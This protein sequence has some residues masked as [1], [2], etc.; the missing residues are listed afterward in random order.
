MSLVRSLT[1]A[2]LVVSQMP[3]LPAF[4]TQQLVP[5]KT[6][7]VKNPPSGARKVLWKVKDGAAAVVGDPTAD[8]AT[9]RIQLTNGG[10]QCVTMPAS[11][12]SAIG[13]IGFKYKDAALANGPVKVAQIK[14]TPSGTFILKALLKNGGP[15]S[16]T[17]APGD[18]TTSYATNFTL[19]TGDEYCGG[20]ATATPNPNNATTF[21]VSNDAAPGACIA[22]CNATTTTSSTSTT[23]TTSTTTSSTTSTT[24][25]FID[26]GQT[27]LDTCTGL[28]W[29]KKD[30]LGALH[31]VGNQ[32]SWAGC[33]DGD[34]TVAS[35]FC[36]PDAQASSACSAQTAGA[37]GCQQCSV[38]TCDIDPLGTGALTT[39]WDWLVQVNAA[40]FAGFNDWRIS[41][42][43]EL[44]TITLAPY[45]CSIH[46]CIDPVFSPTASTFYWSAT[47]AFGEV[48]YRVNFNNAGHYTG[49]ENLEERVRAVR[50][51]P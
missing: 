16:I 26:Q 29:E 2:V 39:I 12:W 19:G 50:N 30:T 4:A 40:G 43:P 9:L 23:S 14:K 21:K 1:L 46:P 48:A 20:T 35:N 17:V 31:E 47:H 15:T 41:S 34:C 38:G 13:T 11:G 6:L 44:D 24:T 8:G 5:T 10:D 18:P 7:L 42:V 51:A 37:N 45:P 49:V 27:V 28:L 33:C 25:C 32:Y 36:Q 3:A 22:S